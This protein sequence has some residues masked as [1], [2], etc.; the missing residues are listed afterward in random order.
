[1]DLNVVGKNIIRVDAYSKVTGKALYPQDIYL[2]D[3]VY[4]KVLRSTKPHGKIKVDITEAEKVKGI[5]KIFT[6]KDV[7]KE[8]KYG[9]VL[10]DHEVFV[11]EKVVRIGEPIAF[12][13]GETQEI[14][15][16]A[17][18]KIIVDYEELNAVFDPIEAMKE[19]SPIVHGDSNI[20]LHYKLRH[21]DI[22][23]GKKKCKYIVENIYRSPMVEHAFL[24]P[25]AGL[26]YLEEDGTVVVAVAT[27]YP[28]YD[29]EEIAINL[30]LPEEKIKVINTNIGGAFGAREDISVQIHLALA[31]IV[32]RRPIK[33]IFS[34]E[35]S[36]LA[37]SKRH[38]MVMKYKTGADENGFL[39][40]M[41]A[42][43]IGDSGAHASWA[44][45]VLRKAGVHATGPY[46]IPNVN[47][48]SYAV[49]TNN[50][51][52]GAMRGFGATQVSIAYEQQIDELAVKLGM[53]PIEIRMKNIFRK[54]SMTATG[55]ILTDSVP[56]DKCI[57]AV[58]KEFQFSRK[59]EVES[60]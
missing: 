38:P 5:L 15:E 27:Q 43:I 51:F 56:L 17:Y 58:D 9:V 6:Y 35:E 33:I 47:V 32:L 20:I 30:G 29:R 12:I 41:E 46:V 22:E 4:G 28:H 2:E 19:D 7:P 14:C 55:Q 57:E 1:M 53:D 49:Y 8:N 23:E 18:E 10:K 16:E 60:I 26:S 36:F 39:Q 13:V 48:D 25:E 11:S 44:I 37:H 52:T 3:M 45:N 24:Q 31:A 54:G 59:L 21:G 34:R 40:Y 42:E 50:P